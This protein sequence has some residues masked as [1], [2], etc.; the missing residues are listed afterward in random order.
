METKGYYMAD[1]CETYNLVNL[2]KEPTCYKN[3]N[4]PS[5]IDLILT[6]RCKLFHKSKTFETGLSDCHLMTITVMKM[7]YQKLKTNII[8]YRDYKNFRNDKFRKMFLEVTGTYNYEISSYEIF[9]K[10]ILDV[11]KTD[12]PIKRKYWRGNHQPF[13]NK[14]LSKAIMKRSRLR[15]LYIKNRNEENRNN[16]I[17]QRNYCVN[18]LR[19][20]KKSYYN[21]LNISNIKDN[22]KFW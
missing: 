1:F 17:K 8:S 10:N 19:K 13:M 15:N 21:N 22:R 7:N 18:L 5:S 20:V 11:L 4:N 16:Y 6:N 2:I 3:P 9:E 12:A 14:D